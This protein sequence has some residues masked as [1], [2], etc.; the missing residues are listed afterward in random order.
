MV[1][2]EDI[3]GKLAEELVQKCPVNVFDIEDTGTGSYHCICV[4]IYYMYVLIHLSRLQRFPVQNWEYVSL[5]DVSA[6]IALCEL[7]GCQH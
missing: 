1:L 4:C 7:D 6:F 3:E 5:S 2:L